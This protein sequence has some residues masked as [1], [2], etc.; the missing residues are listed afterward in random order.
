M[1]TFTTKGG[2]TSYFKDWAPDRG[3]LFAW[4]AF[5]RRYVGRPNVVS[6]PARISCRRP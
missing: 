3:H 5:E 2:T 6:R 4:M 1:N